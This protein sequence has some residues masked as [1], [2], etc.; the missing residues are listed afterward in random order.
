MVVTKVR[1]AC[2]L[3]GDVLV[4]AVLVAERASE[5]ATEP[6][7][8]ARGCG[9]LLHRPH[10]APQRAGGSEAARSADGVHR[11]RLELGLQLSADIK[12]LSLRHALQGLF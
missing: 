9:R 3:A 7:C 1:P 8:C 6:Q 12:A 11:D 10:R 5:P 4:C 2:A